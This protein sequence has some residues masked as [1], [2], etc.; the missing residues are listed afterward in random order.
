MSRVEWE[1]YRPSNGTEGMGF[2]ECWCDG[3]ARDAAARNGHP[4]NGCPI[5]A[6]TLAYD[7]GDPKYPRE[8]QRNRET[9]E[10][11]CT[12]FVGKEALSERAKKAHRTRRANRMA[13]F[14]GELF[15]WD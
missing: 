3:C 14:A 9:G 2:I 6:R 13:S 12:A 11:R 10:C 7:I 1:P 15:F 5:L 4:E 8:W